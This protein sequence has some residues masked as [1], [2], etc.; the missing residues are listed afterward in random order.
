MDP[1]FGKGVSQVN[2]SGRGQ[3]KWAWLKTTGLIPHRLQLRVSFYRERS[4]QVDT[5]CWLQ[6]KV[7]DVDS[8]HRIFRKKE[9]FDSRW[10]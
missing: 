3:Q 8:L 4:N 10:L 6:K 9:G 1:G 2:E 5:V 7:T